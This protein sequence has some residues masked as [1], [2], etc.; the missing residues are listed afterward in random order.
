MWQVDTHLRGENGP[1]DPAGGAGV[2][3]PED[4]A[5][6][7]CRLDRR[8]QKC[9][10]QAATALGRSMTTFTE[11]TLEERAGQVLESGER[12]RLSEHR[13]ERVVP[14][15]TA[16]AGGA[17]CWS[18]TQSLARSTNAALMPPNPKLLES[19]VRTSPT[20]GPSVT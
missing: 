1:V 12:I 2:E 16:V 9:A 20:R 4:A 10:E 8:T 6:L 7:S 19:T 17:V 18:G 11:A 15:T 5:R 3:A 13:Y 14:A